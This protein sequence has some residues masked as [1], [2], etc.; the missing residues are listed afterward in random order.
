MPE[1]HS[2]P[3]PASRAAA[4]T[5]EL[6]ALGDEAFVRCAY[7][8]LFGREADASGL[9]SYLGQVRGGEEKTTLVIQM[10]LSDEGRQRPR[11]VPGLEALVQAGR[12]VPWHRRLARRLLHP[13]RQTP[14]EPVARSFRIME[15]R[16][17]RIEALLQAQASDMASVRG[18]LA[19]AV[20]SFGAERHATA[21]A[22]VTAASSGTPST[23]LPRQA[24]VR[25]EQIY[26]SLRRIWA[27][28]IGM[29]H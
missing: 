19:Q 23:P 21:A 25:V 22:P 20:I 13:W 28:R 26:R 6:L 15:N 2:S 4:S 29:P 18:E 9:E 14:A 3:A 10:A 17:A 7:L 16:L 24:P 8:T 11:N 12:T 5:S 1:N 27:R